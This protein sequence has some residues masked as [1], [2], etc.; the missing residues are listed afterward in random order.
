VG[1]DSDHDELSCTRCKSDRA[2]L[3]RLDRPA[4]E[5]LPDSVNVIDLFSG[6]GGLSLGVAEALRRAGRGFRVTLAMDFDPLAC[7][8]YAANF[9]GAHV[10]TGGVETV[11]D[12]ELGSRP[13]ATERHLL[14]AL[15]GN[16][17]LRAASVDLLVGGPP[18]QGHSDLNNRSRRTDVRNGLYLRMARAAE[19]L[20]PRAVL[21]ENVPAVQHATESVVQTAQQHLSEVCGYSV[22]DSIFD[23]SVLGVPQRRK[24]HIFLAMGGGIDA[25][26]V[27]AAVQG[28][29]CPPRTVRW[30]IQDLANLAGSTPFDTASEASELNRKRMAWF[31]KK[32]ANRFDLPDHLRPDCHRLKHHSYKSVYGRLR[33]DEPAQTITTGFTSMGQGRYVHP[34]HPRT[35]TPH[36]AARLQAFPDFFNFGAERRTVWSKLI[37]NAVPPPLSASIV[38]AILD[39]WRGGAEDTAAPTSANGTQGFRQSSA[40]RGPEAPHLESVSPSRAR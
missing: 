18:C 1:R 32:P 28:A 21:I 33:W 9:P 16:R 23:V 5:G 30:A 38:T 6:C 39:A 27:L 20:R 12:G 24:R 29:S 31:F 40:H 34:D 3:A 15:R 13:T 10:R 17:S 8:V 22:S 25:Q 2:L 4:F 19:V 11:F 35:L 26:A 37:G 7:E 14:S 36:E